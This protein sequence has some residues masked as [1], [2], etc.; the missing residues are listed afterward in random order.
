[1]SKLNGSP[2]GP[3]REEILERKNQE[4]KVKELL[5]KILEKMD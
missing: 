4:V 1:M 5:E 2:Y 3:T